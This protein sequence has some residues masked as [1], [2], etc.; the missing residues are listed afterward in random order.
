MKISP[1]GLALIKSFEGLRLRAYDDA[2]E[3]AL[4]Q[5]QAAKGVATIGWGHTAGVTAGMVCTEAEAEAWLASDLTAVE[6]EVERLV[7][8]PLSQ[9]QFDALV[10]FQYN[11]GW[12]EHPHCSLL[13]A[14]NSGNYRLAYQDFVLY[15]RASGRV[16][17]GLTWRRK[18]EAAM[19]L[20]E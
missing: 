6:A 19:F 20:G 15:N 9:G 14:L 18:A 7:K 4:T 2:T 11:T 17:R 3:R 8:V 5:G 10:S 16:L 13:A 1:A 12:L